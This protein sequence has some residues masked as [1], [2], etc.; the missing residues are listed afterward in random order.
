MSDVA[1]A[2]ENYQAALEISGERALDRQSQVQA[3]T[4]LGWLAYGQNRYEAAVDRFETAVALNDRSDEAYLGLGF[5][6]YSLRDYDKA[7]EAWEKTAELTPEEPTIYVSLGTL[8]WRLGMLQAGEDELVQDRCT[9]PDLSDAE[10]M[11]SVTELLLAIENFQKAND[12]PGRAPVDVA[13]TYQS[14]ARVQYLLRNCPGYEIVAALEATIDSYTAAIELNPDE[15]RYWHLRGRTAYAVWLNLPPGTGPSARIWL[16]DALDDTDMALT[17]RPDDLGDYQPNRWRDLIYAH[18]VDGSLAQGDNRFATGEYEVA[19]GYYELV[20]DRA[21]QVVRAPFKAGLAAVAL[22]DFA[23]AE[24]WYAAGLRL[25]EAADDAPSVALARADLRQFADRMDIDVSSLLTLLNNTDLEVDPANIADAATAFAL[26]QAALLDRTWQRAA[27]LGNL[28]IELAVQA[29][30]IVVVREAGASLAAYQLSYPEVALENIY[31]PSVD[32]LRVRET[33][34]T[35]LERPDLYWRYRAEYGFRFVQNMFS[36]E[37]GWEDSAARIYTQIIADIELAYELNPDEHQTW[38]DFF[39]DANLGWHYLRRG[40]THYTEERYQ[41]ALADYRQATQLIQPDSENALNDLT[42]ATF[43]AGLTALRLAEL[44]LA[45]EAYAA[46]LTLL[47]RYDGNDAQLGRARTD[48][49][50]LLVEEPDLAPF[51]GAILEDLD[52]AE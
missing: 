36:V 9:D 7:L 25:A 49:E 40:D 38:R 29:E 35:N 42:E 48:L 10:K 34:V 37:P 20:A 12:L 27:L 46:G 15:A 47:A 44:R 45:E 50:N 16:F 14:L 18:A 31:W 33:A 8:H 13:E 6:Y 17:L 3:W 52:A 26:A 51:G 21:P 5:S 32:G 22:N 4:G 23:Q 28:G 2:E 30:E 43:K 1:A 19:L 24:T 39:V 41:E 11:A